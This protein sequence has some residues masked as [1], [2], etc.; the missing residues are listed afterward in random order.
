VR[1]LNTDTYAVTQHTGNNDVFFLKMKS[2]RTIPPSGSLLL[3]DYQ[4][5]RAGD[6]RT[7]RSH[8][9]S[10]EQLSDVSFA[11]CWGKHFRSP[12]VSQWGKSVCCDLWRLV[13]KVSRVWMALRRGPGNEANQGMPIDGGALRLEAN[14]AGTRL[15]VGTGWP[16]PNSNNLLV[17]DTASDSIVG[18]FLWVETYTVGLTPR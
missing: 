6:S 1:F 17:V 18:P 2:T 9:Q 8:R 10:V 16:L 5:V 11:G 7:L 12:R 14:P 13:S 15:F 4:E 3:S